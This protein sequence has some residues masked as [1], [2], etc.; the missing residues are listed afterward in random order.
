MKWND[1]HLE[2]FQSWGLHVSLTRCLLSLFLFRSLCLVFP[3][4]PPALPL[5]AFY[6]SVCG[7]GHGYDWRVCVCMCVCV[8]DLGNWTRL[9]NWGTKY[10]K[11]MTISN[12]I[13]ALV[14][15]TIYYTSHIFYLAC[16]SLHLKRGMIR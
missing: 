6:F 8:F 12:L 14:L 7:F 11:R 10:N 2:S 13:K 9:I 1:C 16:I 3:L 4:S 5:P 15:R